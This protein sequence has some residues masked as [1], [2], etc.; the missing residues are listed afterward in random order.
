MEKKRNIIYVCVVAVLFFGLSIAAWLKP[1][2]DFS[3][4]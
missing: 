1:A 2:D 4:T 3:A